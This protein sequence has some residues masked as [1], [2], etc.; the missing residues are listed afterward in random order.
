VK[1]VR[2]F[3]GRSIKSRCRVKFF[4]KKLVETRHQVLQRKTKVLQSVDLTGRD[5]LDNLPFGIIL[6]LFLQ[7]CT[8]SPVFLMDHSIS[9]PLETKAQGC[10]GSSIHREILCEV[11]LIGPS[12]L[13]FHGQR[14]ID[15]K[16]LSRSRW[17][18]ILHLTSS[19][20]S[21]RIRHESNSPQRSH[22]IQ[23]TY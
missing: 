23:R 15:T 4:K 8:Q 19:S 14:L 9:V 6:F 11:G 18:D 13:N 5:G 2:S 22:H 21:L 1:F 10:S 3:V 16:N 20:V 12:R 7:S 17:I